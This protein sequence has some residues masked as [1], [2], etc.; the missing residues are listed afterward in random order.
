MK[1]SL[2]L[3]HLMPERDKV[4]QRKLFDDL[5][6]VRVDPMSSRFRLIDQEQEAKKSLVYFKDLTNKSLA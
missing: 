6:E 4:S 1:K 2:S 5:Q 3:Q